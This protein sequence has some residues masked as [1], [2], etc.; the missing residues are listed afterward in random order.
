[1]LHSII[2]QKIELYV[3]AAVRTVTLQVTG[4]DKKGTQCLGL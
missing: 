2:S 4:G 3:T 1:M